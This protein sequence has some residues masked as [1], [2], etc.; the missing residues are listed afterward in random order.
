MEIWAYRSCCT[1]WYYCEGRFDPVAPQP[2][3]P[4]CAADPLTLE[5]RA[6]AS[7]VAERLERWEDRLVGSRVPVGS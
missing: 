2:H 4:V 1:R 3:C 5:N 6:S 7:G